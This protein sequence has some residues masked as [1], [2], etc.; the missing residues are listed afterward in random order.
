MLAFNM[1]DKYAME[2]GGW[3][4]PSTLKNRYQHTFSDEKKLYDNLLNSQFDTLLSQ[5]DHKTQN[6]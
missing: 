4:N 1:P 5:L 6:S 3:A 2:R